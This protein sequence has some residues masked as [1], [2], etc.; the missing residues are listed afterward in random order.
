MSRKSRV[1]VRSAGNGSAAPDG[2]AEV[3][4]LDGKEKKKEKEEQQMVGLFQVFR[5]A[6]CLDIL[7]MIVGSLCAAVNGAAL[8][9]MIIVFGDMIDLFVDTGKLEVFLDD[10]S[11]YL[12]TVGLTKAAVLENVNLLLP[13]CPNISTYYGGNYTCAV[14]DIQDTILDE[15]KTYAI[16]Y[17]IIGVVVIVCGYAQVCLWMTAAERQAHRIRHKFLYNV[18]RQ[19]IAWFDT[20]DIGELNTRLADDVLKIHDGI[21]DKVGTFVQWN[22][23]AIAGFIIGF[24]YGWKL[25]L[26][27]L[28][29]SPLLVISAGL[30][31]KLAASMTT[32]ELQA[33]AKAGAVAEE[34]FSSIRT[35]VAFGGQDKE[36]ERYYDNLGEARSFGVKKGFSN[37]LSMGF[38]WLVIFGSYALGFWY[39]GKLTRDEPDN[40]TVGTMLISLSAARGAAFTIFQLIDLQP[41]IDNLME[42]GKR[43]QSVTGTLTFQD[44]HFVYPSRPDVKIL[45]GLNLTVR[46][47]QTVALVGS[48]G[49]GKSTTVQLMQRFYDTEQGKV[50]LDGTDIREL[51]VRW[52]REHIGVVSQEPVLFATTI[53]ENISYGREGVSQQEIEA[54]ARNANAHDFISSLP[55]KYNT[56]VG[57]RG[58]QLSGG[59]KQRVAIARALVRNPRIL[60]LDEATSALD[61]E[62]EKIVQDAL[63]KARQGRTTIVVAHRLSTIKTAD[64]IVGFKDGVVS[65]QGT[66]EELMAKK[67]IYFT[68]VTNQTHKHTQEDEDEEEIE[69]FER[70]DAARG[71]ARQLKRMLSDGGKHL[72]RARTMSGEEEEEDL[73]DAPMTRLMRMN[74]PEWGYILLGCIAAIINGGVQPAFAVIFGKIIG[75]F[76]NP[77]LNEQEEDIMMYSLLLAGLG[78][79]S[80]FAMFAQ[81]YFFAI[82]GENLTVRVRDKTFRAM[83]HQEIAWYDE[84]ENSTGALTTRL[85]TDASQVQ[86]ATGVRLGTAIMNLA[87]IGTGII[88]AFIYGW[89]LTLLIIGFLPLLII[90]GFLQIR[91]LAGVAG[92]NKVALEEAGKTATEA[93][94]NMRTVVSLGKE[95]TMH[96]R[97]MGH[98]ETP[99]KGAMKK[100]HIVGFAF[101]FSQGCIYFVYAAAFTLGAYL[102][103]EQEM[104]FEDFAFSM[105]C[106]VFGALVFTAMGLGNASAFAPDAGKAK[107]SAQ[108]IIKLLD[109]APV[110]DTTSEDGTKLVTGYIPQVEFREVEF[111]YPTRPDAKILQGLNISVKQSETVALVGSSG[112][113]K[114]TTVQLIERFYDAEAG[115]VTLGGCDVKNLN[116][117]WLRAQI[118]IV[119]QEPVLFDRSL[120]ENIAYGDNSRVGY[121]TPAGDK[122]TQLSGGQKQRVAIARALVRNPRVLLLDEATSALDTESEKVVQEALDKARQGRTCIV[123]AHRLSTITNADKIYVIR[124]GVVTEEGN[125]S[126]LMSRQGFYYKLQTTQ[127]RQK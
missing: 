125:H 90:G 31:G 29:V 61:T 44:V 82:S 102:I 88:I 109:K 36:A 103:Q 34:V 56:L 122:G 95:V 120:A 115:S 19:D 65:E 126:E 89:Q 87:N 62:S 76:S 86:G 116:V 37:G 83:M 43:P 94:E 38:V 97:F 91:I 79:I 72:E 53:A 5:F 4:L 1:R 124:H 92:S 118:G 71:S 21:G 85:A 49:C 70:E 57:E 12:G 23:G 11:V 113:G 9:A 26:V 74:A 99:Y 112:C 51:N 6:D 121:D 33:Y 111:R 68:L 63:D 64:I 105:M 100:A 39:G 15:M 58:A 110:I 46:P 17:I 2:Q 75:V 42:D 107:V 80:C 119:S 117:Q 10:I 101:G 55:E 30:F 73:P 98:L 18:L 67:G 84:K 20:H 93:I 22:C 77:D 48:S 54:A 59:Q 106:R 52:L 25:T 40:Y 41:K 14:F 35:V 7:M 24:V 66:H 104:Q 32:K 27:I 50:M 28:A 96:D 114:S 81:G 47:G 3:E 108:R 8:P 123:I 13:H 69:A 60:L 127:K 16:Y 78:V 45:N